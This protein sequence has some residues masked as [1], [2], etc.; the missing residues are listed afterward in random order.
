MRFPR[1][2]VGLVL[3]EI[4]K[5]NWDNSQNTRRN[6]SHLGIPPQR[7][8]LPKGMH[9]GVIEWRSRMLRLSRESLRLIL[10]KAMD[11]AGNLRP[12]FVRQTL[13]QSLVE[14][15]RL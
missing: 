13:A 6:Y 4:G 15:K 1:L 8:A 3:A 11:C 10:W 2:R 7:H 14:K 12:F 5:L 9:G